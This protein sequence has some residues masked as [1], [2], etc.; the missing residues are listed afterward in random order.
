[1]RLLRCRVY[2]LAIPMIVVGAT[3]AAQVPEGFK[4]NRYCFLNT[5]MELIANNIVFV[6]EK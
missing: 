4:L 5:K 1:M 2:S 3:L 6:C